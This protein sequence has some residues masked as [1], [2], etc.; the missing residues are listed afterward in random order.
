MFCRGRESD[1]AVDFSLQDYILSASISFSSNLVLLFSPKDDVPKLTYCQLYGTPLHVNLGDKRITA[2]YIKT[3]NN[4][5][6]LF[7]Y[8]V[9][10]HVG[11]PI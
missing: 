10:N 4:V 6:I 1:L 2:L 3:L 8:I 7:K 9:C 11:I 5:E